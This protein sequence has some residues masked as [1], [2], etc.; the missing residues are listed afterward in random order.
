MFTITTPTDF[1][2]APTLEGLRDQ[3]V[4]HWSKYGTTDVVGFEDQVHAVFPFDPSELDDD[5]EPPVVRPLTPELLI[6]LAAWALSEHPNHIKIKKLG[7]HTVEDVAAEIIVAGI[8]CTLEA[9]QGV[10]AGLVA[11]LEAEAAP[12]I[13]KEKQDKKILEDLGLADQDHEEEQLWALA[14]LISLESRLRSMSNHPSFG[15]GE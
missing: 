6:E 2:V 7:G 14:E 10:I 4:E 1:F 8:G 3:L 12:M 5:E 15:T 9:A 11:N 13:F